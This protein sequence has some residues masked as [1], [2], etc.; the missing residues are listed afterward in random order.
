MRSYSNVSSKCTGGHAG[1][2]PSA[3]LAGLVEA[4]CRPLRDGGAKIPGVAG[5]KDR[6]TV[7]VLR[8]R[9]R[10]SDAK[11]VEFGRVVG[12]E[13]ARR[14]KGGA[15]EPGGEAVFGGE[16]RLQ[17]IELQ[18]AD[19][20]DDPIAARQ[21]LKDAGHPL[22]GQLLERVLQM[23]RLHRVVD[24][25]PLQDFGRKV[26]NAGDAERLAFGQSVADPQAPVVGNAND[27]AG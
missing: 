21:R 4:Q 10:V 15:V 16:P 20:T 7:M 23:L 8:T 22:L 2:R 12:V 26:W 3:L 25:D 14:L 19:D 17:H 5:E 11:A 24:L 13:P 9:R 27:V 6:D 1:I 18:R